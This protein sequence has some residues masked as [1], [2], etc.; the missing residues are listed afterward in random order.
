MRKIIKILGVVVLLL[1]L[2]VGAGL[3][4]LKTALPNVGPPPDL[5]VEVTKERIER[6]QHL[7]T[8][9]MACMHCHSK[10]DKTRF[11]HPIEDDMLGAGGTHF[12]PEEGLPGNFYAPNLTPYHLGDWT[13]G[14]IFRA[15]TSGVSKDGHALFPIMPYP[16]YAQIDEEDIYDVIAYLRSLEPVKNDVPLSEAVF[17][18]NFIINTMPQKAEFT[19]KPDIGDKVAYGKY[20][21]TAASCADCHTTMEQGAPIPG[22]EFA[23]GNEFPLIDNSIVRTANIT[24]DPKTGIGNWT[25]EQ[26]IQRFK[27]Y[28]DSSFVFHKVEKGEFNTAM[29][30]RMY[31]RMSQEELSAIYAYLQTVEP[32]KNA[33]THF[34]PVEE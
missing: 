9:V 16:N 10:I 13:D 3:T 12:G 31:S 22:M 19:E 21:V 14:E 28:A 5:T 23:G 29:P 8:E 26:F 6:G 18:V 11:A 1:L 7:A 34:T 4:Y 24:P 17:P 33:V 27:E 32:K 20:L 30:W 15:I 25:E 2:V